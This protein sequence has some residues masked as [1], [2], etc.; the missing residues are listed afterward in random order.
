MLAI[1]G[2]LFAK[3]LTMLLLT[4]CPQQERMVANLAYLPAAKA[5][6]PVCR[7]KV[8]VLDPVSN[9]ALGEQDVSLTAQPQQ[10][11]IDVVGNDSCRLVRVVVSVLE[12]CPNTAALQGNTLEM[13]DAV[14]R[15]V[16]RTIPIAVAK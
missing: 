12:G 16:S 6:A 5:P 3:I 4:F 10:V 9:E 7:V 11:P 15:R 14:T 8:Q 13:E 1:A 2:G